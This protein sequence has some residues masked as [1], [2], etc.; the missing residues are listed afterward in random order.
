MTNKRMH[1]LVREIK[2][3]R[4]KTEPAVAEKTTSSVACPLNQ[5]T[6]VRYSAPTTDGHNERTT[7]HA[8]STCKFTDDHPGHSTVH[9]R[10]IGAHA[11]EHYRATQTE[12]LVHGAIE[13]N[14]NH[15]SRMMAS[16]AAA[17][18]PTS[19]V[20]TTCYC[21]LRILPQP[22]LREQLHQSVGE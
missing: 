13:C 20:V 17:E 21:L 2:S 18:P 22:R 12:R 10:S 3:A 19:S 9:T 5:T 6:D 4:V 11:P 14:A 7:E 15:T 16:A 1:G 8:L